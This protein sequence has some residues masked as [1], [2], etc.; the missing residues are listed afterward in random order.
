LEISLSNAIICGDIPQCTGKLFQNRIIEINRNM[1]DNEIISVI[2]KGLMMKK[3]LSNK[4]KELSNIIRNK[5]N[6]NN[7]YHRLINILLN[8]NCITHMPDNNY[9]NYKFN[10]INNFIF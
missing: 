4:N 7:G 5:H 10:I 6:Y 3:E 8:Y 2:K 1:N 9:N